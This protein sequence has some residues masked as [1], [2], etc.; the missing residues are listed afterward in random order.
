MLTIDL[1]NV[2]VP[3]AY[4]IVY[5]SGTAYIVLSKGTSFRTEQVMYRTRVPKGTCTDGDP[6]LP[7]VQ[8]L[9]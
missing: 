4:Y 2:N 1:M 9:T 3:S 5:G 7:R 8:N 6:T